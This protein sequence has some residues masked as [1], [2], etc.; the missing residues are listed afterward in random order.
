M[1]ENSSLFIEIENSFLFTTIPLGIVL[2][3]KNSC[4]V[5]ANPT[6][7]DILGLTM[8]QMKGKTSFDP[9]WKAIKEDGSDF[10]GE[11]HPSSIA[12]QT[13]QE[14]KNVVMGVFNPLKEKICWIKI[15]AMPLI[16]KGEKEAYGVYT[17]FED[18]TEQKNAELIEIA[19]KERLDKIYTDLL[20]R[21]FAIDQHAIVAVT[22]FFGTILY[23]NERFCKI[24]Q[25]TSK[26]LIGQNHRIINSGLHSK[27]FFQNLYKTIKAGEIWRGEIRNRAKNG[28]FYWVN[29]TIVPLKNPDG[30][31]EQF[32]SI[33]TDI[34]EQKKI[35]ENL[36]LSETKIRALLESNPQSVIFI[37]LD[38]KIQFY[39]QIANE[40]SE[41]VFNR[42][43]YNGDSIYNFVLPED[44]ETFDMA[45]N[46]CLAGT[47]FQIEKSF[48]INEQD[49]WFEFQFAPVKNQEEKVIGVLFTTKDI[50]EKKQ[51]DE[52][53]TQ[54]ELR[55]RTI[56]EQAPL[57][58]ALINSTT[59]EIIQANYKF[60]QILGL[61]QDELKSNSYLKLTHPE[62]LSQYKENL[63]KL[64]NGKIKIFSMEIR[65]MKPNGNTIW[66]HLTCVLLWTEKD[67]IKMNLRILVDITHR[68]RNEEEVTRYLS[69]LENL[70]Q[71]KNK[72]FNIIAH[73]LRNPFAGIIGISELL[74]SQLLADN[75]E[76]SL[77]I[78]KC[79][80]MIKT[81][82]KSAFSLLENLMQWAKS[83]TG[84]ISFN[85]TEISIQNAI[86]SNIT[87]VSGNAFKKNIS[88]EKQLAE[89]ETIY[90][91]SSLVDTILRNLLTNAIKFTYPNGQIIVST[92]P[93]GDFLAISISDS[94][95]GID[96]Q[97]LEK[98]FR[99]DS[100]FSKIG[101]DN[102]KGS[103]LGLVL[104]KEFVEKLGGQIWVTS[105]LGQGT[106]FTFTLPL[107]K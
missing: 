25:Y 43:L 90:A 36:R 4:I 58:I 12:L 94:G 88:I 76:S 93:Q 67:S 33:Q 27:F 3:D 98:I 40:N 72:F 63:E 26:E 92:K 83:Q 106:T 59:S 2:H 99:I 57:G 9:R 51:M 31:I 7:L 100:K 20:Q 64:N 14:V 6:A 77:A 22:D 15:Q 54:S 105:E 86:D 79:I 50:N 34:T 13:N 70:N 52:K 69:E 45:Y 91:D 56:F 10:P 28:S 44:L 55:F 75:T 16:Q 74:E 37:D 96:S 95:V 1:K 62:D 81:S 30:T 103:G 82:S 53:L 60:A 65:Y 35:Q 104:C 46:G 71:T 48:K 68:K 38:K 101:T 66:S 18:I 42:S 49:Y 32:I 78:L 87:L 8:D 97:N 39:N 41:L 29:T 61:Q 5:S 23:A 107:K 11:L 89:N 24:S 84:E 102:E 85:P 47:V 21:Q 80:Q 19:S 17:C 73:D